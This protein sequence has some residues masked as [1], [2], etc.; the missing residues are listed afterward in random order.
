MGSRPFRHRRAR[1]YSAHADAPGDVLR[2]RA[3]CTACGSKGAT[4]QHPTWG[5]NSVG[6]LPFP[7]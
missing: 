6:F 7:T 2:Q 4:I 1:E 5:G 3:R